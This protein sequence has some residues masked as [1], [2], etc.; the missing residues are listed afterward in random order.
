MTQSVSDAWM[1][2]LGFSIDA[3]LKLKEVNLKSN[4]NMSEIKTGFAKLTDDLLV[5]LGLNKPETEAVDT[6]VE[7]GAIKSEDGAVTIQ[8]EGEMLEVGGSVWVQGEDDAKI[9]LP[10]GEIPLEDGSVLVI[11]EEGVVAEVK[12]LEAEPEA[13]EELAE[14]NQVATAKEVTDAIKS[15]LIKYSE[16]TNER[17]E[18]LETKLSAIVLENETLKKEVVELSEQPA[19]K[20]IK[21]TPTQ[22][23]TLTKKGRILEAIRKNQ[24]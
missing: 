15:V 5:A 10:V 23:V 4:I 7:F 8:F 9:P 14:P 21:A 1:E 18:A 2:K 6:K 13:K 24:N 22:K 12:K 19:A 16:Q 3:F 20:A 17:I 11:A